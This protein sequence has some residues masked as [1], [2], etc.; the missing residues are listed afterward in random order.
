MN[1]KTSICRCYLSLASWG[2]PR[3]NPCYCLIFDYSFH[4]R[5]KRPTRVILEN[6]GCKFS[7]S[8]EMAVKP[9]CVCVCATVS[10][11]R[12]AGREGPG[13]WTPPASAGSTYEIRANP[14]SFLG[15]GG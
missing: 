9:T 4:L 8:W 5:G 15:G 10:S 3:W 11:R 2:E 12:G 7:H 13:V 1:Y 14:V 6:H